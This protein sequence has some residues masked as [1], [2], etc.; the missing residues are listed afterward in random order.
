MLTFHSFSLSVRSLEEDKEKQGV[1]LYSLQKP[2]ATTTVKV[3][4]FQ[5]VCGNLFSRLRTTLCVQPFL[6]SR[7]SVES[8]REK[9]GPGCKLQLSTA[10]NNEA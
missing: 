4:L 5:K 6:D 7:T 10:L 9:E 1:I 3:L 8:R 2:F